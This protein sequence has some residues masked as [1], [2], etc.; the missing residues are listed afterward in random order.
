MEKCTDFIENEL[1]CTK[2]TGKGYRAA[3]EVEETDESEVLATK[4]S[5]GFGK[6][7]GSQGKADKIQ[8]EC[9][10][11]KNQ[12]KKLCGYYVEIK[13]QHFRVSE[14]SHP[15]AHGLSRLISTVRTTKAKF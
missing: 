6:G 9:C 11:N 5:H 10:L 1:K 7:E 4:S 14:A 13:K 8:T 3:Y 15:A 2:K 12:Y